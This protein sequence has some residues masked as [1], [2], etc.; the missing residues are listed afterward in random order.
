MTIPKGSQFKLTSWPPPR[1]EIVAINVDAA[2]DS[3]GSRVGTGCVLRDH[4][5]VV[6]ASEVSA[7]AHGLAPSLAEASAILR[8][9]RFASD[10]GFRRVVVHSD[11]LHVINEIKSGDIPTT[12]L[13]TILEDIKESL[14]AFH[15]YSFLF[16][17]RLCNA[18]AHNL[19]K[20]ALFVNSE[21]RWSGLVPPCAVRDFL[22]DV[23]LM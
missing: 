2:I 19:A 12:E 23:S 15:E 1:P 3:R 9:L 8:G 17:P 11:C 5:G 6:L 14:G 7:T 20:F 18:A 10:S 4:R 21:V 13:G 22:K 16:I